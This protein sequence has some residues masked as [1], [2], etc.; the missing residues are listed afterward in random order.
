[1]DLSAQTSKNKKLHPKKY[2]IFWEFIVSGNI[3]FILYFY[4]FILELS[5]SNIKKFI[6]RNL[7][8]YFLKKIPLQFLASAPK[9][10]P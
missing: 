5:N 6:K 8:S 4:I 2:F 7:F 1:M 10:L 3:F 9:S